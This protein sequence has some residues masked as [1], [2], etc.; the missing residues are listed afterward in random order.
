MLI[1]PFVKRNSYI[2]GTTIITINAMKDIKPK[3]SLT[4]CGSRGC[5]AAAA[6]PRLIIEADQDFTTQGYNDAT[7]VNGDG[8]ATIADAKPSAAPSRTTDNCP[9]QLQGVAPHTGARFFV[10]KWR[11]VQMNCK[12]NCIDLLK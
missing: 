12:I 8:I 9:H 4:A 11:G 5:L 6:M 7:D 2:H 1:S 10:E 3:F